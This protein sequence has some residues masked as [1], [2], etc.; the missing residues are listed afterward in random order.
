[1]RA[2]NVMTTHVV[3][4]KPRTHIQNIARVLLDR[5]ISAV[6]VIDEAKKLIGIVS[7]GDLMR[8]PE[9]DT[10]SPTSWWL[11]LLA[12]PETLAEKYI[13]THGRYAED[14]MTRHVIA[15][16]EDSTLE[17]IASMME[18]RHIK[19]VPIVRD[20]KVVGIVSRANL[21]HGLVTAGVRN[22]NATDDTEIRSKVVLA[23]EREAGVRDEFMN[24]TVS[25]GVVHLWGTALSDAEKKAACLAAEN[26]DGVR[27]IKDHLNVLPPEAQAG[28]WT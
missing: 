13:K 10:A 4:V 15:A 14:I 5:Q 7:E 17:E 9:A 16:E 26:T 8:R 23:L 27:A 28:L 22:E 18:Q 12:S 11:R 1:M 25:N 19:R 2:R 6:P 21:L 20:E 3:S 24:I